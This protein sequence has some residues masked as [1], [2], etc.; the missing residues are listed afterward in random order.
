MLASA[1]FQ[2][3][4]DISALIDYY[5]VSTKFGSPALTKF[6]LDQPALADKNFGRE[7]TAIL[8]TNGALIDVF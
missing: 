8:T 3:N 4:F 2:L 5:A 6:K 7:L 1:A